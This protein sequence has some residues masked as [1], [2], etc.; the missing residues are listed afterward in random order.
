MP[1]SLTLFCHPVQVPWRSLGIDQEREANEYFEWLHGMGRT[2]TLA[3]ALFV[4]R[5][6]GK[7][8][9]GDGLQGGSAEVA[10]ASAV[11]TASLAGALVAPSIS[12]EVA[13]VL[14][15]CR[16]WWPDGRDARP[17]CSWCRK[18]SNATG[19]RVS[20]CL[21][22]KQRRQA[23]AE[24]TPASAASAADASATH[25]PGTHKHTEMSNEQCGRALQTSTPSWSRP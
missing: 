8:R 2:P 7:A 1:A 15:C 4:R 6:D 20:G 11:T 23:A 12:N 22:A 10:A 14:P 25:R 5:G 21:E 17:W 3:A 13:A 24:Q 16:G 18:P 19:N 9:G